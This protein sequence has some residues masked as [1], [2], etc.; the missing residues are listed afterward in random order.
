MKMEEFLSLHS[1]LKPKKKSGESVKKQEVK[2][3]SSLISLSECV[4]SR[5]PMISSNVPAA[6]S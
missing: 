6:P 1:F 4:K 3:S 5:P 2:L